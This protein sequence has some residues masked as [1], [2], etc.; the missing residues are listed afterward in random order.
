MENIKKILIV[1]DETLTAMML[2]EYIKDKGF[3]SVS[4]SSTGEEAILRA[5]AEK[6]DLI[7]MD[8]RL[9]GEMNGIE[10]AKIIDADRSVPIVIISGY[11]EHIILERAN[12]YRPRAILQKP[13]SDADIDDI[14]KLIA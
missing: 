9:G 8:F 12:D 7:F 13:V 11:A 14:L 5:K 10:A 2:A 3:S 1:E 4:L 6:P